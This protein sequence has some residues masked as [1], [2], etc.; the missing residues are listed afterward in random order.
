MIRRSRKA[1]IIGGGIAGPATAM[2]LRSAGFESRI[3]EA[4]S[5]AAGIGGGLQIAPNGMHVLDEL[6]LADEMVRIG[7]VAES[8]L[9]TN[10]SGRLL[11]SINRDMRERFGQPAVNVAR[12]ALNDVILAQV[13]WAGIEV[14]FGKRLVKIE[15]LPDRPIAAHFDDGTTAEGDLLIG[16]D[17][18]HSAVRAHVNPGGPVPFDT[19]L[20]GFGG[21]MPRSV[22]ERAGVGPHVMMTLGQRGSFGYGYCSRDEENGA[23]WWDTQSSGGTDAAAFRAMSQQQIKQ[24]IRTFHAGWHNPIPQIIDH[25]QDIIVTDTLDIATLPQWSRGRVVLIGD[26]A[27]ATTPHAGQGA[28]IALED[29]LRLSRLL[30]RGEEFG[31]TFAKFEAERR[32]R[33]E[34]IVAAARRNGGSKGDMSRAGALMRDIAIKLLLPVFARGQDWMY[35]YNPRVR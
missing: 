33:A 25:A 12:A 22:L 6:G 14:G 28:S 34:R 16:A 32:P 4:R 8:M 10:Q 24:H 2:F 21:F 5:R 11:G 29:G 1:I 7:S 31:V 26:A 17:G 19:G 13:R 15:D 30:R 20:M 35:Q 27:H 18:V 9:F 3:F 23:M